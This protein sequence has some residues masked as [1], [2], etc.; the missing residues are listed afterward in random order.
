MQWHA[1]CLHFA[2]FIGPILRAN[3]CNMDAERWFAGRRWITI[4][5]WHGSPVERYV[6]VAAEGVRATKALHD[7]VADGLRFVGTLPPK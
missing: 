7:W 5:S 4:V 3:R 2:S 6:Y 1:S